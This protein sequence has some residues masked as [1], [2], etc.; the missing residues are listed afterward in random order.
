MDRGTVGAVAAGNLS[1][2]V[3]VP[4][5]LPH[6]LNTT[7]VTALQVVAYVHVREKV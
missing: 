4:P 5:L 7:E 3:Q 6:W 1:P 2:S